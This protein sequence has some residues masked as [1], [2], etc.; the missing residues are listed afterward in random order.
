MYLPVPYHYCLLYYRK[1][2]VYICFTLSRHVLKYISVF[3][4]LVLFTVLM[5]R[6]WLGSLIHF[7]STSD[8]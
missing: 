4:D 8:P 1:V 5:S 6:N 3:A 2:I 7:H